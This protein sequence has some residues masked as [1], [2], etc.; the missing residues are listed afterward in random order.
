MKVLG[1]GNGR[2]VIDQSRKN[3]YQFDIASKERLEIEELSDVR[4]KAGDWNDHMILLEGLEVFPFGISNDLPLE[5]RE[6]LYQNHLA[7]RVQKKKK[8]LNW[9]QGPQ[10]YRNVFDGETIKRDYVRDPEVEAWLKSWDYLGYLE[11]LMTDFIYVEDC[12]SKCVPARS[13]RINRP[14]VNR[15]EHVS[16]SKAR[17]ARPF[18]GIDGDPATLIVVG[19]W[20]QLW[21]GRFEI[22]PI[23]DWKKLRTSVISSGFYSFDTDYYTRPDIYGVLPWLRRSSSIPLVL[24]ALSENSLN[25]KYHVESPAI[26]WEQERERLEERYRNDNKELTEEAWEDYK[27]EFYEALAKVLAS[28]KNVGK[29]F[30][31]EIVVQMIGGNAVEMGWKIKPIEQ[32]IKD[33]VTAQIDISKRADFAAIAALG[34]HAALSNISH[35]GKSDSGSEQLY[36]L[37]NYLLTETSLPEMKITEA[38]NKALSINFPDKDIRIGFYHPHPQRE[39]DKSESH[40]T[41]NQQPDGSTV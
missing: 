12:Y 23:T 7:P 34:L 29:F 6:T 35:E 41:K 10:L 27:D 39:Q 15:L 30:T 18:S 13:V 14:F 40:R 26:F 3:L 8:L 38:L 1:R 37:Q 4:L 22:Y 24:Q 17:Y 5:I 21:N 36:A 31:S 33:Y 16:A 32:N 9:G 28:E 25:V 11:R 20:N 2:V 19:N